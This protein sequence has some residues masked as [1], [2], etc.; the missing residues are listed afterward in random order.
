ML[1]QLGFSWEVRPSVE[2]PKEI[3]KQRLNELIEYKSQNGNFKVD[4]IILPELFAWCQEQR[5]TLRQDNTLFYR[6]VSK[7]QFDDLAAIGFDKDVELLEPLPGKSNDPSTKEPSMTEAS[8][9]KVASSEK[10]AVGTEKKPVR[11]VAPDNDGH[12]EAP[13]AQRTLKANGDDAIAN[14]VQDD[15]ASKDEMEQEGRAVSV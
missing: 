13:A 15:G 2:N 14:L 11:S 7:E 10:E 8:D 6:K 4:P 12:T 1:D 3:W 5:E 9:G